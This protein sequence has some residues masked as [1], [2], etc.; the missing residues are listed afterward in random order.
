MTFERHC[1]EGQVTIWHRQLKSPMRGGS[2]IALGVSA[3]VWN[4]STALGSG[5][6]QP[7]YTEYTIIGFDQIPVLIRS[8]QVSIL[9]PYAWDVCHRRA[10]HLLSRIQLHT[11][12]PTQLSRNLHQR[13]HRKQTNPP[14]QQLL[15]PRLRHPTRSA[16]STCVPPSFLHNLPNLPH[17][18]R[19]HPQV[20]RLLRRIADRIPNTL[21][22]LRPHHPSTHHAILARTQNRAHPARPQP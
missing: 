18:L 14:P 15:H 19:P 5:F 8:V 12:P 22:P 3:T 2:S 17:Q 20:R 7:K 10:D 21:K 9:H 6:G 16:A 13:I 1:H 4:G 11:N